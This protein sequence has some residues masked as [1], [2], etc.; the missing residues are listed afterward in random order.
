MRRLPLAVAAMAL[1][2]AFAG[3]ARAATRVALLPVVVH[4]QDSGQ[5]LQEGVSDML[6]SRLAAQPGI[7]VVRLKDPAL[8]TTDL[9]SA[10]ERGR[11]AGAQYVLF[12]SFTSFGAGA[13]L[14]LH[15]ARTDEGGEDAPR[16]VFG[17]A[18]QLGE[19]IPHLDEM[20]EKVAQ[21][22]R[23]PASR[24]VAGEAGPAGGGAAELPAVS[25]GP[26][27]PASREELE[28]LRRRVEALE[29]AFRARAEAGTSGPSA[30]R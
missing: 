7:E 19:I 22:I 6:M 13:S 28:A 24:R 1:V 18:G 2:L 29:A 17:H 5:Y 9:Q 23:E 27:A 20:A 16:D 4:S 14:D 3:A 26:G 10:R 30:A 15:C 8:A 12:G 21:F 11:A 25:A